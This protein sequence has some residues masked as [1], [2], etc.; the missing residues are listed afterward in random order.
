M[1][2]K[3]FKIVA[4]VLAGEVVFLLPFVLAR[5]FR[6]TFLKV[7]QVSNLELGSAFAAYGVV[8][9]ISYFFG[10]PIADRYSARK[11]LT[12]SLVATSLGGI[13]L[14][15]IPSLTTLTVL[16]A[17]W[18]LTTILLFWAAFTKSTRVVG[19]EK[20]QG[21]AFGLVDGGRG[22]VAALLASGS[23]LILGSF[24]PIDVEQASL[25][26]LSNALSM[27]VLVFSVFTLLTAGLTWTAIDEDKSEEPHLDRMTLNGVKAVISRSSIWKQSLIVLCAYVGYKCTDDFSL[28][29][30]DV[31]N[32]DDVSAAH[33]ATIAFW[34]RPFAAVLAGSLGDRLGHSKMTTFCFGLVIAGSLTIY[35]GLLKPG[36][37]VIALLVLASTSAAVFGLR[38]LYYALFQESK[39][40]MIYTGSAVG[41]VSVIGFTPDIFFGP[42]MGYILDSSPGAQGHQNL[43][44]V[45]ACFSLIGLLTSLTFKRSLGN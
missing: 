31:L 41:I 1:Y 4:L 7:F 28:F 35:A 43:F 24:L 23:V 42:M 3:S 20:N 40:P 33:V 17:F 15:M 27:V 16:Y 14:A 22:L 5:V 21:N 39:I 37:E 25:E 26:E 19:G 36:Y 10:G 45:L 29:A 8:A 32:Y 44:G 13:W 2:K 30:S 34:M 12:S 11:L 18:G 9:M 38:G 6:P